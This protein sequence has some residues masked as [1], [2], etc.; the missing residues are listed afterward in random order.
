MLSKEEEI[1]CFE[2]LKNNFPDLKKQGLVIGLNEFLKPEMNLFDYICRNQTPKEA[3]L[4]YIRE[5]IAYI[6]LDE[7]EGYKCIFFRGNHI[8]A[9]Y[10]VSNSKLIG[11]AEE[12]I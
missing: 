6:V 1:G 7:T 11:F 3:A 2:I 8:K 4:E 9:Q 12:T 10:D 5:K